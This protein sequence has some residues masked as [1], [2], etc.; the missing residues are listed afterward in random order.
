MD[1]LQ[2]KC[3]GERRPLTAVSLGSPS[4]LDWAVDRYYLQIMQE[5]HLINY[6][7]SACFFV[8]KYIHPISPGNFWVGA[9]H[10]WDER[11]RKEAAHPGTKHGVSWSLLLAHWHPPNICR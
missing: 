2:G 6:K 1:A 11:R 7:K 9:R 10:T 5:A 3:K 4:G 8:R